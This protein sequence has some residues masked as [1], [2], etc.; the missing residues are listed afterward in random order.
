[1]SKGEPRTTH[2]QNHEH[3]GDPMASTAVAKPMGNPR[4][5]DGRIMAQHYTPMADSWVIHR[6]PMGQRF[7]PLG[8]PWVTHAPALPIGNTWKT[9]AYEKP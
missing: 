6:R 7:K 2:G 4:Q 9:H 8:E 1:M 3:L 5:T